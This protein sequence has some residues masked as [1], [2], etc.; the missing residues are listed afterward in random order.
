M[1]TKVG[2]LTATAAAIGIAVLFAGNPVNLANVA[3]SLVDNLGLQPRTEQPTPTTQSTADAEASPPAARDTPARDE[4]AASD[5]AGQDQTEKTEPSSDALFR[6][7]QA[8]AADK[9]QA[10]VRPVQPAQDTPPR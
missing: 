2:I 10:D 7:F 6:Q 4:I 5:I 9:A 1:P 3:A 8:W